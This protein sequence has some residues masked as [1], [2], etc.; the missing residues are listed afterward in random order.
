M[1]HDLE[2]EKLYHPENFE[3]EELSICCDASIVEGF[4]SNCKDKCWLNK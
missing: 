1:N 4:C 3:E 2:I